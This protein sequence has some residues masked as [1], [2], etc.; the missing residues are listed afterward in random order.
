VTDANVVLGYMNP[1]SIADSTLHINREAAWTVIQEKL[2][3]PLGLD[4]LQAAYG[5]TQVANATMMRALRAVS[6]ERGRDPREFALIAFGGAGPIH[7]AEL[8]GSLGMKQVYVPLFP[9]LFSALGLLLADFRHD[10]VRSVALTLSKVDPQTILR[11]YVEMEEGA[12]TELRREGL[13]EAVVRF[14]RWAD[15]KYGYQISE[16]TLPFP[17]DAAATDLR[18]GLARL[19]TEAHHQ[20]FGYSRDDPIELVSVRLRATATATSLQFADLTQ[21]HSR[22]GHVGRSAS[23]RQAYFGPKYGLLTTPIHERGDIDKFVSGPLIV[24][25]PDT[26]VVVPPGWQIHRDGLGNLVMSVG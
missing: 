7:A 17:M 23:M 1:E 8:A 20:E 3:V 13:P 15:L 25:E 18:S 5:I 12:R 11:L 24:E 6:T 9:G 4:P 26:T 16:L 10:Y 21:P 14:E 2:A 19:F 22:S